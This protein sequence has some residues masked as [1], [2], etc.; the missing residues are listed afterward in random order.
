MGLWRLRQS[1]ES[2]PSRGLGSV[3]AEVTGGGV[4]QLCLKGLGE[5]GLEPG[6][7]V[8]WGP[9]GPRSPAG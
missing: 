2:R 4:Q 9:L 6:A 7:R 8:P 1:E 5:E 3:E